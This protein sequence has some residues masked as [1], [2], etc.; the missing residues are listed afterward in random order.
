MPIMEIQRNGPDLAYAPIMPHHK[1]TFLLGNTVIGLSNKFSGF[2]KDKFVILQDN[3]LK[4]RLKEKSRLNW[5]FRHFLPVCIFALCFL[6]LIFF[7]RCEVLAVI[8][9]IA[10]LIIIKGF[11]NAQYAIIENNVE[12][13]FSMEKRK[14]SIS[15]FS[16]KE[17]IYHIHS[18]SHE[19][20]SLFK[21]KTQIA[22]YERTL[23][24][25]KNKYFVYYA[26]EPKEIIELFGLW[27]DMYN[28]NDS[29]GRT[30]IR[31][32]GL[33]DKHPEFTL[34]RPKDIDG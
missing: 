31:T 12:I 4:Y 6:F 27:I 11:F 34:W 3:H 13:G 26:D 18:H 19:R 20:Y 10:S 17:D 21:N 9:F 33:P 25:G 14:T 7:P 1:R 5:A 24:K 23:E 2:Q 28:Y 16:I 22:L 30:I 15:S 32:F 8:L 29:R